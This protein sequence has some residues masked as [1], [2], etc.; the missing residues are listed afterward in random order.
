M[1]IYVFKCY[2]CC[3][4][5]GHASARKGRRAVEGNK[6]T[7]LLN[8]TSYSKSTNHEVVLRGYL[9]FSLLAD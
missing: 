2:Y 7:T 8:I 3:L 5:Y 4:L 9:E 6:V 1:H